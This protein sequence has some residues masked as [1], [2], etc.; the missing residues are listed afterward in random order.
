MP[1]TNVRSRL[2]AVLLSLSGLLGA[3][4]ALTALPGASEYRE[5]GLRYRQQ[6]RYP[7]AIAALEESVNLDPQNTSSRVL[8][9]WTLH[10]AGKEDAAAE[11]LRQ[12]I[13]QDLFNIPALNAMGIVCLVNGDLNDAVAAHSWALMLKPDNEI[14]YYNLSLAYHGLQKYDWAIATASQAAALEP[15]NPHPLVA[16]AIAQWDS[17]NPAL[18]Q[19]VYRQAIN[20]D[21]RYRDRPF[22]DHLQKAG[23]SPTQIQTT[24]QVLL[25][26]GN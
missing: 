3:Q 1:V 19:Q 21:P 24:E 8:L 13:Y 18:A 5:L 23:F 22:L 16:Q 12:A 25:A 2:I 7:E 11:A 4:P 14:A 15:T 17:G 10:L 26:P 9:G 20:L 6:E